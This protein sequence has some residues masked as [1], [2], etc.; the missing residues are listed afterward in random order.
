MNILAG[1]LGGSD[2]CLFVCAFWFGSK[3]SLVGFESLMMSLLG[4]FD[5]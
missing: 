2:F 3:L 4:E 1:F 5:M